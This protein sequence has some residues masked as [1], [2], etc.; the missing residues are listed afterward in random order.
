MDAHTSGV[1]GEVRERTSA[2]VPGA[3][4]SLPGAE[5][6]HCSQSTIKSFTPVSVEER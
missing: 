5:E 4:G 1:A 6:P 3:L 2:K